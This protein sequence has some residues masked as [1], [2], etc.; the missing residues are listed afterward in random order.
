VNVAVALETRFVRTPDGAIWSMGWLDHNFWNRY[1][2]VFDRVSVIARVGTALDPPQGGKRA[3]RE[4]VSFCPIPYYKGPWQYAAKYFAVKKAMCV[5]VKNDDALILRVPGVM[6]TIAANVANVMGKPFALEVVGDPAEVFAGGVKSILAPI[7]RIAYTRALRNQCYNACAI[8]YVARKVLEQRYPPGPSSYV[9]QYSTI[10]LDDD[11]FVDDPRKFC[12]TS[13]PLRIVSVGSLAQRYKGQDVLIRAVAKA[14]Q[15]LLRS[16]PDTYPVQLTL[17]GDGKHRSELEK[18]ANAHGLS[19]HI[20][21]TGKLPSGDAVRAE[22][23]RADLFVMASRTE[24]LPRA[25]IEAMARA[26]PCLGTKVGGIPELLN[27]GELFQPDNVD[28]LATMII[29]IARDRER[30]TRMSAIN[31]EKSKIYHTKMLTPLR[32]KLYEVVR[33]QTLKWQRE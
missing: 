14:S 17:V 23:D 4:K 15:S 16:N 29:V 31:L 5:S 12:D 13:A 7:A 18:M 22:L 3:D 32:D 25:M 10:H 30:L 6:G 26:T 19:C 33:D 20:H 8:S 28:N 1:L 11:A 27:E 2:R 9:T 21:F 24:G